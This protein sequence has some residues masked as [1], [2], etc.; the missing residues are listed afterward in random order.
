MPFECR[1]PL[2][3]YGHFCNSVCVALFGFSAMIMQ[4]C[5]I[6]FEVGNAIG[7]DVVAEILDNDK[8]ADQVF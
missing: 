2:S 6:S 3:N 7:V 1:L 5:V 8:T 4:L